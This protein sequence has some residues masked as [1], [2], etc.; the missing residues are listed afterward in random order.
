M[1]KSE[2]EMDF[3]FT[4]INYMNSTTK[5]RRER[6]IAVFISKVERGVYRLII[7]EVVLPPIMK[8]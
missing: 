2:V 6:K 8:A 7:K 1:Q 4:V 5:H 3:K